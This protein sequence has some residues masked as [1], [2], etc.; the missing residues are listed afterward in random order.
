M[1]FTYS[2]GVIG[3]SASTVTGT[4]APF[5][6]MSGASSLTLPLAGAMER[7]PNRRFMVA[8]TVSSGCG[9]PSWAC[10]AATCMKP[11]RPS[12]TATPAD[13]IPQARRR[14]RRVSFALFNVHFIAYLLL[15]EAPLFLPWP[16]LAFFP[17][18]CQAELYRQLQCF[19]QEVSH[20]SDEFSLLVV[21]KMVCLRRHDLLRSW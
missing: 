7:F 18:P 5:S 6:A 8:S 1:L 3:R 9:I 17:R 14:A 19:V 21:K 11:P 13:P 16:R 10:C 4:T 15:E 12:E 2:W 20:I